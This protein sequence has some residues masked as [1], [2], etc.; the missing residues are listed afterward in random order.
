MVHRYCNELVETLF[1]EKGFFESRIF[2][3]K[4]EGDKKNIAIMD[5]DG[6]NRSML[7]NNNTINLFPVFV[8]QSTVL[9]TSYQ[10]GKP[11]IYRGSITEGTSRM[12][13]EGPAMLVSPDVSPLDGMVAY[14]SSQTGTLNIF[15]CAPDGTR[16]RQLTFSRGID[17]A[18][19]WSPN[20]YQ[21]AFTSDRAGGPQIYIMDATGANQRRVTF[22]GRYN[23]TPVWSP[24]GDRIAYAARD[25][26]QFNI[27]V[28]SP[29]GSDARMVA[30]PTG[31]NENPTWSPDG[32]L[33]AFINTIG[34][35]SD[36]YIV[37]SD[38]SR[39]RRVTTSGDVRMPRWS[40]FW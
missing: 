25:E 39:L 11:D 6:H 34:G 4:N 8:D 32:S 3:V 40:R 9:W 29:D 1:A 16:P 19:N 12:F 33:I 15:V 17:T 27:W 10:R 21:I 24:R 5:F 14:A 2:Y 38:G 20:G 30:N 23:D 31:M 28:V 18:P 7:T 26:G 37:R 13:I 36:L 22:E 35:R